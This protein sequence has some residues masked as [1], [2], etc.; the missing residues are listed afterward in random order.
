MRDYVYGLRGSLLLTPNIVRLLNQ[1][2]EYKGRQYTLIQI[3][4]ESLTE[5][6]DVARIQSTDASNRIEGIT[7]SENRLRSLVMDKTEPRNRNE[8][9]IAGYRDVLDLINESHDHIKLTPGVL[10]QLHRD[11]Y[12]Y[13]G[14]GFAG[15]YK[16]TDNV[17]EE[18]DS[19]GNRIIR[20]QPMAAYETPEGIERICKDYE[21]AIN[22][23]SIDPLLI[24]SMTILDFLCVH[25]F[26]DGNGRIS[27]I[28]TLLLLYQNGY[29]IGK[30]ISIEK[31]IEQ[32]RET[33]YNAL[34]ESSQDWYQ[35]SNDYEPFV[36]Y[37]LG[38][39]LSAY[40]MFESN[41]KHLYNKGISKSDRVRLVIHNNVGSIT[42]KEIK[43][44]CPDISETTIEKALGEL[45]RS[46]VINKVGGGRI[47][48][49]AYDHDNLKG[50]KGSV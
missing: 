11:L 14:V 40:M 20:F 17:I 3:K 23:G 21:S 28:L 30:Y 8:S 50:S 22:E 2:H 44:R 7:I 13:A 41:T 36:E 39:I 5:L 48:A 29:H 49:Y 24:I 19:V 38:V 35:G 6:L 31:Q 12:R 9:E 25:P 47:T 42:K 18:R 34:R 4:K 43:Q 45:V 16:S 33:Y 37:A 32:S 27:R 10:L 15:K 26:N 1:I 46:G